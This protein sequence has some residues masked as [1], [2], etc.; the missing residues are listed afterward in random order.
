M[1]EAGTSKAKA[2]S[3]IGGR[4]R[5]VTT[6]SSHAIRSIVGPAFLIANSME[7]VKYCIERIAGFVA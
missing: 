2:T 6:R 4:G 1:D 5:D 7:G 3:G